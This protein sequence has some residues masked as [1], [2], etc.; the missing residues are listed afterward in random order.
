MSEFLFPALPRHHQ[1]HPVVWHVYPGAGR[2]LA[3]GEEEG[4]KERA[5]GRRGGE[6]EQKG[7]GKKL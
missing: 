5:K 6:E 1:R 4:Y 2:A 3:L 7:K